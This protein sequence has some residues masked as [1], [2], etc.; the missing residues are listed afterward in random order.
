MVGE[1][2]DEWKEDAKYGDGAE[3]VH[4]RAGLKSEFWKVADVKWNLSKL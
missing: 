3:C 2:G 1:G 4:S